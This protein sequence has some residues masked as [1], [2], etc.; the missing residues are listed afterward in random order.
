[1]LHH[2]FGLPGPA[3][4]ALGYPGGL[5]HDAAPALSF[6]PER[7]SGELRLDC[8]VC[9]VGSGA[10]GGTAAGVLAAAGLDV[11]VLE[12]GERRDVQRRG[13]RLAAPAL[14]R[15]CGVRY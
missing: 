4:A 9:V 7:V 15:R 14:P 1:M 3:R 2:Y 13:D 6:E 10:G 11:V 5:A 12:A 8:D